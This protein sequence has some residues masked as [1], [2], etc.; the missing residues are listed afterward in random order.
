VLIIHSVQKLL[1]TSRLEA[2]LYISQP[3]QGQHLHSWYARLLSSGFP[4]KMMIMYVHEPSLMTIICKGKTIQG[5]WETFL[6]RLHQ[7][8]VRYEFPET[9]I[10]KELSQTEGYTISKT[11]S[12][13]VLSHMNQIVFE[14]EYMGR[15]GEDYDHI[16]LDSLEDGLMGR[17]Y[18]YSKRLHDYRTPLRYWQEEIQLRIK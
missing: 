13:S 2:S 6:K 8:L 12:R 1:N 5:T 7:L 10:Q 11:N 17:P 18:Q 16:S 3:N 4:G 15:M 14:L 9:F